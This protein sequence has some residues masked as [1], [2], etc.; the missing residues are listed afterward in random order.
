M[1][2]VSTAYAALEVNRPHQHPWD[3]L[4]VTLIPG[5]PEP[6]VCKLDAGRVVATPSSGVDAAAAD[7]VLAA[8]G[9]ARASAW[10][11]TGDGRYSSTVV[12]AGEM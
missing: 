7:A 3:I 2:R 8:G 6:Q 1:S 4:V 12:P 5:N 9:W 11:Y 10:V